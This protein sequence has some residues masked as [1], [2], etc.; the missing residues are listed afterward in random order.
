M[1]PPGKLR[2]AAT[3]GLMAWLWLA[4]AG[5]V[6]AQS[7]SDSVM[8][9]TQA[10]ERLATEGKLPEAV[11]ALEALVKEFPGEYDPRVLLGAYHLLLGRAAEARAA[12]EQASRLNPAAA[13]PYAIMAEAAELEGDLAL[14]EKHL[15]KATELEPGNANYAAYLAEMLVQQKRYSEASAIFGGIASRNGSAV[16]AQLNR[17]LYAEMEAQRKAGTQPATLRLPVTGIDIARRGGTSVWYVLARRTIGRFGDEIVQVQPGLR[18]QL[19]M[20][21]NDEE[22]YPYPCSNSFADRPALP[23]ASEILAG[24]WD[25]KVTRN[26]RSNRPQFCHDL[27][28]GILILSVIHLESAEALKPLLAAISEA[29]VKKFGARRP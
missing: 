16:D 15:R 25:R 12:A 13:N 6:A 10:A 7:A 1:L 23:E 3:S 28:N 14:A 26:R 21:S 11:A 20:E 17:D 2:V 4:V 8:Q 5:P 27:K 24:A 29:A 18:I 22:P 9:R 19:E